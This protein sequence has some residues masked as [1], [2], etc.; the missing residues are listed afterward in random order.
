MF[1]NRHIRSAFFL[2]CAAASVAAQE[3]LLEPTE[4][5]NYQL[6]PQ[7]DLGPVEIQKGNGVFVDP[8]G[9]MAVV[10][11]VGATVYAFNAYSG[12]ELWQYQAPSDGTGIARCRSAV[13]FAPTQE[14]MAFT[15]V[16]NENSVSPTSRVIAL[17]MDGAPLWVSDSLDGIA[18]GDPQIS[19]DG[20]YVFLT[21]NEYDQDADVS[22]AHF[23][24]LEGNSTGSVFYTDSADESIFFGPPG[25]FHNP[26]EG[27]YDPIVPGAP[28]SEGENNRNDFLMWS[29]TPRVANEPVEDGFIYGFQ[30]PRTFTGNATDIGFFPLGE[31]ASDFQSITP[32]VI[33]NEGLSAYWGV[34]RSSYRGW[35]TRRF[36]RARSVSAG[37]TRNANFAG[38][39][40][41]AAPAL[42]NSGPDPIIYGGSASNEFIR[43]N[44]E[45]EFTTIPTQAP[46]MSKAIVDGE[47]RAVYYVEMNGNLHQA[48]ADT[49]AD[50]WNYTMNFAVEG[51]M[52]L[53]PNN[54]V[55]IVA[56]RRGVIQALAVAE[57]LGTEAPSA[58]PSD[59]PSMAPSGDD[60]P[61]PTGADVPTD[62]AGPSPTVSPVSVPAVPTASPPSGAANHGVLVVAAM[63]SVACMFF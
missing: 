13:T 57:I 41:F 18:Q 6:T 50:I 49:I 24:I 27:N 28:V 15:V 7:A 8:T 32:P 16:D 55:L 42:S 29:R 19:S 5:W 39:A 22:T 3:L 61:A 1:L 59:M 37:F 38:Q 60:T 33:T 56:D 45:F 44:I 12:A 23:T 58:F 51:E 54:D 53:T 62:V 26:V 4:L 36:S 43:M 47:G 31:I 30:F 20:A 34:S 17:S 48:N 40:V 25:I 21:H 63:A 11:T 2:A 10:T 14:Y 46:I 9:R 52:A 35:N